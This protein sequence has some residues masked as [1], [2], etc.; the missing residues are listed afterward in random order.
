LNVRL[1]KEIMITLE[2][3]GLI[4]VT[5]RWTCSTFEQPFLGNHEQ[6]GNRLLPVIPVFLRVRMMTDTQWMIKMVCEYFLYAL[7]AVGIC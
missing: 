6:R 2:R 3:I 4:V 7:K 1:L 5:A